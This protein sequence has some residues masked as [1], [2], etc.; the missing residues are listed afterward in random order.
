LEQV[1]AKVN[2]DVVY[3]HSPHDTHQDH[4]A[5]FF[6]T[7]VAAR[8]VPSFFCYQSPSTTV[9]FK[10]TK[11]VDIETVLEEKVSLL[12]LFSSQQGIRSYLSEEAIRSTSTYWG[13]FTGFRPSE[14]L[15]VVREHA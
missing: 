3:T 15:E 5:A 4:R 11:F 9:D 1:L 6:A 10:P 14:P 8:R 2:P 7:R 13:R 12:H